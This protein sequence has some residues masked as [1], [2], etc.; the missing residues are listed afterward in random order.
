MNCKDCIILLLKYS[1]KSGFDL[2]VVKHMPPYGQGSSS[3]VAASCFPN[4][5]AINNAKA[6]VEKSVV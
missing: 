4:I 6:V 3:I 1:Q 2:M 5:E